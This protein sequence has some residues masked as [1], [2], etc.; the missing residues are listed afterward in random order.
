LTFIRKQQN[1]IQKHGV[2]AKLNSKKSSQTSPNNPKSHKRNIHEPNRITPYRRVYV[3][4]FGS[5]CPRY[6]LFAVLSGT[7]AT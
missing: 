3:G 1:K 5:E 7:L 2:K 4:F 6:S